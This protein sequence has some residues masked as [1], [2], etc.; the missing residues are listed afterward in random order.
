[1]QQELWYKPSNIKVLIDDKAN[2]GI[3]EALKFGYLKKAGKGGKIFIS[4]LQVTV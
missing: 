4:S 3:F 1:M 2:R